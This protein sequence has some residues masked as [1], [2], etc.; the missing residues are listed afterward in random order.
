MY[1]ILATLV[2]SFSS[3]FYYAD[4]KMYWEVSEK[5]V[6]FSFRYNRERK[7]F[8]ADGPVVVQI[9]SSGNCYASETIEGVT[10]TVKFVI[11]E[12]TSRIETDMVVDSSGASLESLYFTK[13]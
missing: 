4:G 9:D 7:D 11:K 5:G 6:S 1:L 2:F 8:F 13:Q 10:Q 3:N 12:S